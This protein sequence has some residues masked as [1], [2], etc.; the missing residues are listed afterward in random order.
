MKLLMFYAPSFWYQT[1]QKSLPQAPD[2]ERQEE[3]RQAVVAFY[4]AEA[5]DLGREAKVLAKLVKNIR[6]L[7]GKFESQ[8]VVLHSFNHLSASKAPPELAE[9]LALE[10]R[11]RLAKAGLEVSITPFGYTNEWKMHVAGESLA[12]VFKEL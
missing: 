8:R 7:A 3:A 11:E 5:E 12:K 6:W 10:A 2:Q 1:F 9:T 4:Q